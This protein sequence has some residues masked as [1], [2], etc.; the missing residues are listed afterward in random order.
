MAIHTTF[1]NLATRLIAKHGRD[2]VLVS[3]TETG[4]VYNP[5]RT[6]VLTDIKALEAAKTP[7][8]M[9]QFESDGDLIENEDKFYLLDASIEPENNMRL[10]DN[11]IDYEIKAVKIVQPGVTKCLYKVQCRL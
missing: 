11:S 9:T 4:P 3:F 10:R 5:T 1:A 8:V 2:C 7:S 6:E